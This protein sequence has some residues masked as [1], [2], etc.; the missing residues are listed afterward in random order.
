[1]SLS[2]WQINTPIGW[3][4]LSE[5]AGRLIRLCFGNADAG[6]TPLVRS[7]L[8]CQ[9]EAELADYFAGKRQSFSLPL[10][11][12]GTPF[13][14]KCWEALARI[15]YGDT[16]SY[17]WQAEAIGSPKA[18]RAVGAANHRNPLPILIPCHRIVGKTGQLTGYAGG[19]S[20]K[21]KLLNLEACNK[22]SLSST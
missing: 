2:C 5:N 1:M 9:A 17:A 14:L 4:T 3:L 6:E 21:Q 16:R 8:M 7:A 11:P 19:L 15:P 12:V 13:Q 22:T 10:A 18:Y 20:V